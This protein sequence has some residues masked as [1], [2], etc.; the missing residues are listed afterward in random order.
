MSRQHVCLIGQFMV[1]VTLPA[2]GV[3][4][5]LRA[6]GVMH[7]AR[8]LWAID[9]PYSIL[10]FCPA[11]LSESAVKHGAIHGAQNCIQIGDVIGAPNVMLVAEPTE[12]GN[13]GY[14]HL[15]R[16]QHQSKVDDGK[17]SD[18]LQEF[19]FSDA[20]VFPGGFDL[21]VVFGLLSQSDVR[22]FVDANSEPVERSSV[23]K[24]GRPLETLI[25]S[26]STQF[27]RETCGGQFDKLLS[28]SISMGA[29]SL[30]LKENRGGTRFIREGVRISTP[31]QLRPIQHSVGV[32]DCFDAVF[33]ALRLRMPERMALAYASCI[34]AEYASTTF[35][36]IFRDE[37]RAW[38]QVP[39][40]EIEKLA[41]VSVP[42]ELR[43]SIEI[44]VAAPDFDFANTKPIDQLCE[45][46]KYHNFSPRRPVQEN[47]QMGIDASK[48]RRQSLCSRDL[49]LL[50]QCSIVVGVLL[51]EDP[52]T[53]IEIGIA[54][55]RGLPVVVYDP[56]NRASNLMLTE[57]PYSVSNDLDV[58]VSAVFE[59]AAKVINNDKKR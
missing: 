56:Y 23:S 9:C 58:I 1:D 5:K 7:A 11:Y 29:N 50:D 31:A 51:Y 46:L 24:L 28:S 6:G 40:D 8:A 34:A 14:E 42:W 48:A 53:L 43:Q 13:Q 25:T 32:G 15:L 30:M 22:V 20:I 18:C 49:L 3:G 35:P 10:F 33:V 38:L 2:K 4:Y 19:S 59:C 41:G 55:E 52:G 45:C 26:T 54:I 37:T 12:A 21:D 44:Y 47:G 17:L 36:E 39:G 16:D 57:L 27:F